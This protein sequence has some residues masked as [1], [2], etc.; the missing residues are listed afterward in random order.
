VRKKV[1]INKTEESVFTLLSLFVLIQQA[2]ESIYGKEE[3]LNSEFN[4]ENNSFHNLMTDTIH[5]AL[6]YQILLKACAFLDEW[7]ETFGIKTETKDFEKIIAVKKIARP[8]IKQISSWKQLKD[9]RNEVI[10]HN[11]RENKS[12]RNIYVI[13]KGYHSPDTDSEIYL[14]VFCIKKAMDVVS[15]F[16]KSEM[17]NVIQNLKFRKT[18]LRQKRLSATQIKKTI[19][20]INGA[21]DNALADILMRQHQ[22]NSVVGAIGKQQ[23]VS[24]PLD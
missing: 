3:I 16:Y 15:V 21:I 17:A 20:G 13:S 14:M 4:P 18:P 6:N 12:G 23:P 2:F 1:N 5:E 24:T 8:A 11:H 7:N 22:F 9:F 19:K 10:A